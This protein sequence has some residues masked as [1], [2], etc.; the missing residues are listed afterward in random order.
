MYTFGFPFFIY[1]KIKFWIVYSKRNVKWFQIRLHQA[2]SKFRN[3]LRDE[4]K[5]PWIRFWR[6]PGS[7]QFE[8]ALLLL[9]IKKIIHNNNHLESKVITYLKS[10]IIVQLKWTHLSLNF[11][12]SWFVFR[13]PYNYCSVNHFLLS[14]LWKHVPLFS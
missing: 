4:I 7:L 3:W 8:Y 11:N 6:K 9:Y 12:F 14:H 10:R 5:V 2:F 1:F 13:Q